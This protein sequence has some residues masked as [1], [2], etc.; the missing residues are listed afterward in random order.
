LKILF[1]I[2]IKNRSEVY[3]VNDNLRIVM[4]EIIL[5]AIITII[6]PGLGEG[7]VTEMTKKSL[8]LMTIILL[9]ATAEAIEV[10]NCTEISS[11][12]SSTTSSR[13]QTGFSGSIRL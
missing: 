2:W 3:E 5:A 12:Y 7:Q 11:P 1:H 13:R 4:T 10:S 9:S 8:T 6:I